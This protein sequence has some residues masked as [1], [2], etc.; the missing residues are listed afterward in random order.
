[1]SAQSGP[2]HTSIRRHGH[3]IAKERRRPVRRALASSGH[4]SKTRGPL[5]AQD[6]GSLKH[7]N[8]FAHVRC[9]QQ[10]HRPEAVQSV[11]ISRVVEPLCWVVRY[12]NLEHRR[13]SLDNP[14]DLGDR[15]PKQAP[16]AS[17]RSRKSRRV[18][19]NVEQATRQGPLCRV[20]GIEVQRYSAR[21]RHRLGSRSELQGECIIPD[22]IQ[23]HHA[24]WRRDQGGAIKFC[25]CG[26]L[27]T[28]RI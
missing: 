20:M 24:R 15:S 26:S 23:M 2:P 3:D 11:T 1:M 22:D 13:S 25:Q 8:A 4:V 9:P 10:A 14:V 5:V 18:D 7:R 17:R 28:V 16:F 21:S 27:S 6:E 12:A 19:G